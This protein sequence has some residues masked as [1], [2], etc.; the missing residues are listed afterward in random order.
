MPVTVLS[1]WLWTW[2][3]RFGIGVG[4]GIRFWFWL[5]VMLAERFIGWIQWRG[6]KKKRWK[7][8]LVY[9]ITLGGA[10]ATL[11]H[12]FHRTPYLSAVMPHWSSSTS[13]D[14]IAA[15]TYSRTPHNP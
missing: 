4:V 11:L 7:N 8:I 13:L 3:V 5:E 12:L 2:L 6:R 1:V 14:W 9:F 10:L 15:H